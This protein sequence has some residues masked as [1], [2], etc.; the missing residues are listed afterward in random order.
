MRNSLTPITKMNDLISINRPKRTE[1]QEKVTMIDPDDEGPILGHK[2]CPRQHAGRTA[3]AGARA[4]RAG[5][6]VPRAA[7]NGAGMSTGWASAKRPVSCSPGWTPCS[8]S[9]PAG[10]RAAASAA[11]P[12]AT[13]GHEGPAPS[14]TRSCPRFRRL[15]T[16]TRRTPPRTGLAPALPGHPH[17]PAPPDLQ[18]AGVPG[19]R[20]HRPAAGPPLPRGADPPTRPSKR[21]GV[22]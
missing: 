9:S 8:P 5:E 20:N 22:S 16:A 21:T 1:L 18:P 13:G 15:R 19:L 17:P 4:G 12:T 2:A 6:G 14:W 7:H 10:H 11:R 3:G